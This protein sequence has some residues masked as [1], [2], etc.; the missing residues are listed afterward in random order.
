MAEKI[1]FK[2]YDLLWK[3]GVP[4]LFISIYLESGYHKLDTISY[5]EGK[6]N[7]LFIAKSQRVK[8][9]KRGVGLYT[10]G[11]S[12]FKKKL[13][14]NELQIKAYLKEDNKIDPKNLSDQELTRNFLRQA[15]FLRQAWSIYFFTEVHLTDQIAKLVQNNLPDNNILRKNLSQMG[16]LRMKFRNSC[17]NTIM[18]EPG[19]FPKY[20][21]EVSRRLKQDISDYHFLEVVDSL[22][23]RR[24]LPKVNRK[25][26]VT[27]K[28]NDWRLITGN[29]AR[30][31]FKQLLPI[32]K[33]LSLQG[34]VGHQGF[35][36][37]KVRII[38]F[39]L[40]TDFSKEIEAMKKGEVLISGSTGPEMIL[41]CKK[42]GA[43]VTEE[44][45]I[46]SHAAVVSRELKIPCVIGTK[47]ATKVFKTGDLVEVDAIKGIVKK[48]K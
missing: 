7:Y 46:L 34:V 13:K 4:Y 36:R 39:G 37:G 12:D 1:Y 21:S 3:W 5:N 40:K 26:I 44:G 24:P 33:S 41:A 8:L 48:I 10:S 28:F 6:N 9:S 38:D 23:K 16:N 45:G 30:K 35:Y 42:A 32:N 19:P 15:K 22:K 25:N 47:V 29:P 11:F 2:D 31:I 14:A 18:Y 27:G 20:C 43:I 17:I